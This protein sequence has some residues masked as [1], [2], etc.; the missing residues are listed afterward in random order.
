MHAFTLCNQAMLAAGLI[1]VLVSA[2]PAT[3][4]GLWCGDEAGYRR[5]ARVYGY[6]APLPQRPA[7]R[8]LSRAQVANTPPPPGGSTTL[9]PPGLMTTQGIL[10]SPVPASGPTL[11]GPGSAVYGYSGYASPPR[12]RRWRR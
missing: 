4:C 9:D 2:E 5:P 3:A 12:S 7:Q 1:V 6:R 10:D 8:P 11:F